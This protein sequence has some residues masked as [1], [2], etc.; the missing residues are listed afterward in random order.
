MF[1][2]LG[3]LREMLCALDRKER[4]A[5]VQFALGENATHIDALFKDTIRERIDINVPADAIWF[6][7][8]HLDW[9]YVALYHFTNDIPLDTDKQFPKPDEALLSFTN[10]DIDMLIYFEHEDE[11]HLIFI[12]A[13]YEIGWTNKQLLRKQNRLTKIE[14]HFL[15]SAKNC[16]IHFHYI[17]TSPRK[18]SSKLDKTADEQWTWM[19]FP[20]DKRLFGV[21]RC[22][23][24]LTKSAE[25]QR[26]AT[27]PTK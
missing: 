20:S 25:G 15:E 7:D 13:K 14:K 1:D 3:T 9:V 19:K 6:M 2:T 18:P 16:K 10:E 24:S 26:W 8:Y 11:H 21:S 27:F 17:I 5:L 12:E 23:K 4:H 22:D